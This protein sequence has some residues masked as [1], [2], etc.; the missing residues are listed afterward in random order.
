MA[1]W[2]IAEVAPIGVVDDRHA[3][4]GQHPCDLSQICRLIH[5]RDV[6]KDIE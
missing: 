3:S 1:T 2:R 5:W 6:D 4:W